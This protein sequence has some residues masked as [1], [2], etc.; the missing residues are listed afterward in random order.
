MR[1][2][3]ERLRRGMESD[4]LERYSSQGLCWSEVMYAEEFSN[5]L[6]AIIEVR[7]IG[8]P[9]ERF[10]LAYQSE[11]CLRDVIAAPSII[12][13]GFFSRDDAL[14]MLKDR[15]GDG[16]P[17]PTAISEPPFDPDASVHATHEQP[18]WQERLGFTWI[19][20]AAG[21]LL[22]QLAAMFVIVVFSKGMFSTTLRSLIG[23]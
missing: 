12:A 16:D 19:R 10:A 17:S 7:W 2:S 20:K 11:E 5:A 4:L 9:A 21:H 3:F 14:A 18:N 8:R 15:R 22:Q 13:S 1:S 6:Y 23:S